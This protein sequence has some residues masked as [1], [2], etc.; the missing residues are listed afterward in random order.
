MSIVLGRVMVLVVEGGIARRPVHH[1]RRL[2]VHHIT[3]RRVRAVRPAR[4]CGQWWK[5]GSITLVYHRLYDS[6]PRIDEPV[7]NL[8]NRQ[9]RVLCQLLLLVL[10]GV[11]MRE[12]LKQPRPENVGRDFRKD[13]SLLLVLLT[14]RIVVFLAR[15]L[16]TADARIAR[17]TGTAEE[18][19]GIKDATTR[20]VAC[21]SL[22][23]RR[24]TPF[25]TRT[26]FSHGVGVRGIH[27][28]GRL[29]TEGSRRAAASRATCIIVATR[30]RIRK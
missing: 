9:P 23:V 20:S 28:G 10:R 27:A 25:S 4:T 18:D 30:T 22:R 13:S 11:R 1:A 3:H 21:R 24:R 12:V 5:H 26:P 2:S 29:L 16:A 15:A 6:T 19:G 17:V 8:K 14:R 7:I